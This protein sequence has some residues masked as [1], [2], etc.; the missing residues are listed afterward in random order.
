MRSYVA[1]LDVE[2]D[3][4]RLQALF[5]D[6]LRPQ[7]TT[8]LRISHLLLQRGV[9]RGLT[10]FDIASLMCRADAGADPATDRS[11]LERAVLASAHLATHAMHSVTTHVA[12][13]LRAA[14][15]FPALDATPPAALPSLQRT[16]PFGADTTTSATLPPPLLTG[17]PV[18]SY[19]T[20]QLSTQPTVSSCPAAVGAWWAARAAAAVPGLPTA[21]V[22]VRHI[23]DL[24]STLGVNSAAL[25]DRHLSVWIAAAFCAEDALMESASTM[26]GYH[27]PSRPSR[28]RV[29]HR[30]CLTDSG[31]S[32][33][34][35]QPLRKLAFDL[36]SSSTLTFSR[37][38]IAEQFGIS[39]VSDRKQ[40]L[41]S[42]IAVGVECDGQLW[43]CAGAPLGQGVVLVGDDE[44]R[45]GIIATLA[46][47][48]GAVESSDCSG[49][50]IAVRAA[51]MAETVGLIR[52]AGPTRGSLDSVAGTGRLPTADFTSPTR[53]LDLPDD[54]PGSISSPYY[55]RA[56]RRRVESFAV[57]AHSVAGSDARSPPIPLVS[58]LNALQQTFRKAARDIISIE[59]CSACSCHGTLSNRTGTT[60]PPPSGVSAGT[61]AMAE[62]ADPD[63]VTDPAS[64]WQ[65]ESRH[66]ESLLFRMS[67]TAPLHLEPLPVARA[68]A[69]ASDS[70]GESVP[71]ADGRTSTDSHGLTGRLAPPAATAL[72]AGSESSVLVVSSAP[73]HASSGVG[74]ASVRVAGMTPGPASVASQRSFG[75]GVASA[76]DFRAGVACDHTAPG[77][78]GLPFAS[79]RPTLRRMNSLAACE[80]SGDSEFFDS[81]STTLNAGTPQSLLAGAAPISP[82]PVSGP[83]RL[84]EEIQRYG[85]F[86]GAAVLKSPEETNSATVVLAE[87]SSAR[88]S[89]GEQPVSIMQPCSRH[90]E[91]V[92]ADESSPASTVAQ[93]LLR[94]QSSSLVSDGS[95]ATSI[96]RVGRLEGEGGWTPSSLPPLPE[97]YEVA[98]LSTDCVSS[99]DATALS[100]P[101][102]PLSHESALR[103]RRAPAA[104]SLA[105][106]ATY[107]LS[108]LPRTH[109]LDAVRGLAGQLPSTQ[110]TPMPGAE[111]TPPTPAATPLLARYAS[112]TG[113]TSKSRPPLHGVAGEAAQEDAPPAS[114]HYSFESFFLAYLSQQVDE[115]I[116]RT[117]ER[118]S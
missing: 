27:G 36:G 47:A 74:T 43:I 79:A 92:A 67:V 75:A 1:A 3:V 72:A 108:N 63:R 95:R 31:I 39:S 59:P 62:S 48:L 28:P 89:S 85:A 41:I 76:S 49:G 22:R 98:H 15:H 45:R 20:R 52:R 51:C 118:K 44:G 46:A 24:D 104:L 65:G 114:H 18:H 64:H 77:P 90:P 88:A 91:T 115:L 13:R 86:A 82:A 38:T 116:T 58:P 10:L 30:V 35:L 68:S 14:A 99:E 32:N 6:Y 69:S 80:P 40:S 83:G 107:D 100:L 54:F 105:R 5:G 4:S 109:A 103:I 60:G 25:E 7:C 34:A 96:A 55:Q 70:A 94:G 53:S 42:S 106:S 87:L 12:K 37:Q 101:T 33:P 78:S 16:P 102:V 29:V 117:I 2:S 61:M 26:Q 21:R 110:G 50:E 81:S 73:S 17:L 97:A 111:E 8:T 23:S 57:D 11:P 93:P 9:A 56:A 112:E 19:L 66:D 84:L 71:L 113:A